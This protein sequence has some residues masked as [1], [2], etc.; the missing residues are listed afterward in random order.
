MTQKDISAIDELERVVRDD[1]T[2]LPTVTDAVEQQ[3]DSGDRA[4]QR[5]A[6][7]A[8]R[9]AA[10]HDGALVD[11]Y[12]GRFVEFI[13]SDE[14]SLQ[15]S[16]AIGLA[17]LAGENPADERVRAAIPALIDL[18]GRT[19][20]PSIEEAV[21]RGLGYVGQVDPAAVADADAIIGERF[22]EATFPTKTVV[23][24]WFTRAVREEPSLFPATIEAYVTILEEGAPAMSRFAAE[25]LAD[26]ATADP[27]A[28]P[29]LA[30]VRG[31]VESLETRAAA[32]PR[33]EVGE[34]IREAA[35]TFRQVEAADG[36]G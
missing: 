36:A 28:I 6:G 22:P 33:R 29:D 25:A 20:A 4:E 12:A 2:A 35:E 5:D 18:L 7:R 23:L 9:A 8:L 16:G 24:K 17:E 31:T 1:P 11:Q 32:D 30:G 21:I 19:V 3:L 34:P 27:S 13:E 10:T 14:G 15:L 26:V